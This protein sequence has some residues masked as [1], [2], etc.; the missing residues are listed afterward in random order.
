MPEIR[1]LKQKATISFA[2]SLSFYT[3]LCGLLS[4][5]NLS[6][7]SGINWAIWLLQSAPLLLLLPGLLKRY[8]RSFSWLCFLMLFYF[9]RAVEGSAMSTADITDHIFLTL[10]VGL[11]IS[12]MFASRWL[13]RYQLMET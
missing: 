5:W 11:F 6:R 4:Y 10:T 7:P 2:I 12:S 1:N 8:Y 9:V 13:Q 3:A